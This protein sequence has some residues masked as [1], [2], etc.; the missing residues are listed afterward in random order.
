MFLS[1]RNHESRTSHSY[2]QICFWGMYIPDDT[3][4]FARRAVL[5]AVLCMTSSSES[6]SEERTVLPAF[7]LLAL[8][9]SGGHTQIIKMDKHNDFEIIGT[10]RD[11]AVGE[12]FDK[13]AKILGLPYPGGPSISAAALGHITRQ[14]GTKLEVA[15]G[16]RH[17]YKFPHPK[18][19]DLDFSFSGLKTAV[20]RTVQSEL[21]KPISFPSHDLAP[22]LSNQQIADFSAS[23]EQTAIDI[24]LEKLSL[25]LTKYQKTTSIVIAGGVSANSL[26]RQ[27]ASKR[28]ISKN[29]PL[30]FF[31]DKHFS[32]DN[33][34]M[35]AAATYYEIQSGIQPSDPY[36]LDLSPRSP[37]H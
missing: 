31:P 29:T 35:V 30:V 10:T 3:E 33:A 20:L 11:D 19:N 18:V 23:F 36:S 34:A 2:F 14:D 37:I 6:G 16:D 4:R 15:P 7:P 13:I 17:K 24:L 26:L 21:K 1:R 8:V 9:I 5:S 32:G 27:E 28:L 12:C 22:L 25:A